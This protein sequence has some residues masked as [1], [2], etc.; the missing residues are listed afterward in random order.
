MLHIQHPYHHQMNIFN[1]WIG[2][3][4]LHLRRFQWAVKCPRLLTIEREPMAVTFPSYYRKSEHRSVTHI[5]KHSTSVIHK[6]TQFCWLLCTHFI[7][8]HIYSTFVPVVC[9]LLKSTIVF[10]VKNVYYFFKY[11]LILGV[12]FLSSI[13]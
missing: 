12:K 4:N 1:H 11:F 6:W 13:S 10:Y 8:L 3:S 7:Y 9:Q 2:L 5:E